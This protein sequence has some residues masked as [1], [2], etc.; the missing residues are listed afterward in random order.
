MSAEDWSERFLTHYIAGAWRTPL[1]EVMCPT[2]HVGASVVLA[3]RADLERARQAAMTAAQEWRARG[4]AARQTALDA[5]G[6]AEA[7]AETGGPVLLSCSGRTAPDTR[8]LGL[9]AAGDPVIVLG[10]TAD[11][12]PAFRFLAACHAARL[13]AG[14]VGLL[15]AQDHAE[16]AATTGLPLFCA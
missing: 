9:L 2:H 14:V 11:P 8:A 7:G 6:V 4:A 13:P 15:Y 1:S 3:G 12:E 16:V 10:Q 5:L